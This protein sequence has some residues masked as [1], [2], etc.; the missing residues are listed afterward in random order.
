MLQYEILMIV[1]SG[2]S[3]C[4]MS[5]PVAIVLVSKA[6]KCGMDNRSNVALRN[7]M[8]AISIPAANVLVSSQFTHRR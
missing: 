3:N 8:L 7:S 5:V 6:L 2:G 4:K 1:P